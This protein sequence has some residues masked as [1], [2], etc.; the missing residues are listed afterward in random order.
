M[1]L[2][3]VPEQFDVI[4]IDGVHGGEL[5]Y[6]P[7]DVKDERFLNDRGYVPTAVPA[8]RGGRAGRCR[9]QPWVFGGNGTFGVSGEFS[10]RYQRLQPDCGQ[11]LAVCWRLQAPASFRLVRRRRAV[12]LHGTAR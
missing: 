7:R 9:V 8:H 4:Y 12:H 2:E 10:C 5:D 3:F 11:D 1:F 6:S